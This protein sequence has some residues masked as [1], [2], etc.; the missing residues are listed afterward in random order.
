MT[1]NRALLLALR[2]A[3]VAAAVW[4]VVD[5][6]DF[7]DREVTA[8]D[9]STRIEPGLATLVRDASAGWIAL[10]FV[11][12]TLFALGGII[13]WWWLMR[14]LG[15][16]VSFS[17]AFRF[18]YVGHF[19]NTV[20]PGATGGDVIKA[21]CVA[22][23]LPDRRA[24]AVTTVLVDRVLGLLALTV[25]GGVLAATRIGD[26]AFGTAAAFLLGLV[27]VAMILAVPFAFKSARR[28]LRLDR[29]LRALPFQ[30]VLRDVD[31]AIQL[32]RDR[33]AA[34]AGIFAFTI[35]AQIFGVADAWCLARAFGL[36]VPLDDLVVAIAVI[37]IFAAI[38][39]SP[40]GWGIGEGLY[41][42][43]FRY[44]GVAAAPAVAISVVTRLIATAH[45]LLGGLFLLRAPADV[46]AARDEAVAAR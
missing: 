41:A 9:G 23:A 36:D 14:A 44:I 1:R 25:L 13:R 30:R 31:A 3:V 17:A 27:G 42:H 5:R 39:I 7:V 10:A 19:F 22:R 40:G 8:A 29:V 21:V 16:A 34:I 35:G 24:H 45:G 32:Y 33:P 4:F 11:S 6:V 38:P 12:Y 46:R 20:M 2:I 26:G 18:S 43:F 15:L 28:A 37:S